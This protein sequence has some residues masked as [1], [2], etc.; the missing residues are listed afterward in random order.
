MGAP[1]WLKRT[2]RG[3]A[4]GAGLAG[5]G[6]GAMVVWN[7]LRYGKS[8]TPPV[9]SDRLLD[10]FIPE[11]ESVERDYIV[12]NAPPDVV[13]ATAKEMEALSTPIVRAL[14][15][16]RELVMGGTP[17]LRPHPAA[18]L[19]QMQSI[20]WVVLAETA[21]REV[22]LGAV[23]QPWETA[24][25]FRS[26]P[27]EEFAAFAEPGYV[28]IAWTLRADP[29]FGDDRTVFRTETR[30]VTTDAVARA[31]F[32]KYWA[33]VEPGVK[34]I[35]IAMLRPLKRQAERKVHPVAA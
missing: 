17:D 15:K 1:K 16:A 30:V 27:A 14:I 34:L 33:F 26:I 8:K 11:P 6:Y 32:R 4:I 13:L 3:V 9:P 35:R 18:L 22:V 19:A 2:G 31:R 21:C 28:K 23:T 24:P 29:L 25:V 5:V 20:G 7:F 12:I 10:R